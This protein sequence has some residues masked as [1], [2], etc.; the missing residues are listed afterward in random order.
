[1]IIELTDANDLYEEGRNQNHC[2][3]HRRRTCSLGDLRVASV[4]EI[5]GEGNKTLS[6]FSM[7]LEDGKACLE[8][9][10]TRFNGY[11]SRMVDGLS[12]C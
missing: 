6:T 2:V 3:Y 1:M 5:T 4:R 9:H 10:R 11:S 12:I 7:F 8:E